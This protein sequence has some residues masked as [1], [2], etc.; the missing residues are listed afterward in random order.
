MQNFEKFS[1]T[2]ID[3]NILWKTFIL[4]NFHHKKVFCFMQFFLWGTEARIIEM[5]YNTDPHNDV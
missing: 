4:G 2:I 3:T 5:D 1:R